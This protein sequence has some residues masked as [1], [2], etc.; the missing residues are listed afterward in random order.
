[1]TCPEWEPLTTAEAVVAAHIAGRD[2]EYR[3]PLESKWL[4]SRFPEFAAQNIRDGVEYRARIEGGA[5]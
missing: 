3:I 2:V 1:M 4:Q 5:E